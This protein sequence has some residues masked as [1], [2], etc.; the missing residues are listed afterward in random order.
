MSE[1]VA[2]VDEMLE[3]APSDMRHML[4]EEMKRLFFAMRDV[5]GGTILMKKRWRISLRRWIEYRIS[6][7]A[8][9]ERGRNVKSRARLRFPFSFHPP[10]SH[11]LDFD[12]PLFA[13]FTK[14][15]P[16]KVLTRPLQSV[17]LAASYNR[18]KISRESTD[19]T[20]EDR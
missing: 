5:E 3:I 8:S 16:K 19:E 9:K 2:R 14:C 6:L 11:I 4:W 1:V 13:K 20:M 12:Y 15:D 18:R 7:F 10:S 17:L